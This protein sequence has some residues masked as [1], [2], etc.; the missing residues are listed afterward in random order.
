MGFTGGMAY[1]RSAVVMRLFLRINGIAKTEPQWFL[2]GGTLER[3]TGCF[4]EENEDGQDD[5]RRHKGEPLW[6]L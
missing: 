3:G 5:Y 1:G 2:G 4:H 6:T